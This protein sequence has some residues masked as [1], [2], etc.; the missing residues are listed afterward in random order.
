MYLCIDDMKRRLN[1]LLAYCCFALLWVTSIFPMWVHY[2]FSDM[3]Y[4][5]LYRMAGYRTKIVRKNIN[6][7]FPE[8]SDQEVKKIECEF[9][10]WF[11]A[12]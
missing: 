12:G 8:K 2:L 3:M 4:L 11:C 9:Y 5:I 10:H 7:A 1:K 6:T